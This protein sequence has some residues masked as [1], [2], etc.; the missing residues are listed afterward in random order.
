MLQEHEIALP[1][2]TDQFVSTRLAI[3][4][5]GFSEGSGG[6]TDFRADQM[7]RC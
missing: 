3:S 2:E 7:S 6:R 4:V 5:R 1:M